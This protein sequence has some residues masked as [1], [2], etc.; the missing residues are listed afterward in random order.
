MLMPTETPAFAGIGTAKAS[1]K[2]NVPQS[3]FFMLFPPLDTVFS[4]LLAITK[5]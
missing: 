2:N 4:T 3:S 5:D 1:A